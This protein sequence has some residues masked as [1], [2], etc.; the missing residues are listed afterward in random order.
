M[1]EIQILFRINKMTGKSIT[2][3]QALEV[4]PRVTYTVGVLEEE[5][6]EFDIDQLIRDIIDEVVMLDL[7]NKG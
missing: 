6:H 3:D 5:G 1:T 7:L 4:M 2:L